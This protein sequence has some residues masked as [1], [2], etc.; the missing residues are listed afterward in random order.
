[1]NYIDIETMVRN[2]FENFTNGNV[3]P[4]QQHEKKKHIQMATQITLDIFRNMTN[5]TNVE[6]QDFIHG[7]NHLFFFGFVAGQTV[8]RLSIE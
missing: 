1:M 2:D 3:E 5:Y 6:L 7:L 4:V 8:H